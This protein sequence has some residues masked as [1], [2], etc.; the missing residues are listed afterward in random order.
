MLIRVTSENSSAMASVIRVPQPDPVPPATEW[1]T[2][3]VGGRLHF[4]SSA[5]TLSSDASRNS[6]LHM[7]YPKA[8]L[9]PAPP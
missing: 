5:R 1:V 6:P 3:N 7:A 8:Q 9:F 2:T 4:S